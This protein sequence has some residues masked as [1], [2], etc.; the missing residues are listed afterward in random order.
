MSL[1]DQCLCAQVFAAA[2]ST[3]TKSS[4]ITLA[5][6]ALN[7]LSDS[8]STGRPESSFG[9]HFSD[10]IPPPPGRVSGQTDTLSTPTPHPVSGQTDRQSNF[11]TDR[12]T[13]HTVHANPPVEFWDTDRQRERQ[14]VYHTD[15]PVEFWDTHRQTEDRQ[16]RPPRSSFG[17]H[18]D[19]Q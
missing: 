4:G 15:P 19:R 18:T 7:H 12:H 11:G 6:C 10:D 3:L 2:F 16:Y 5:A 8:L 1:E 17:T 9:T 14:T 13:H